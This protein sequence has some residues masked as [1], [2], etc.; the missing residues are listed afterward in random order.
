MTV[1]VLEMLETAG[2]MVPILTTNLKAF[3]KPLTQFLKK[4]SDYACAVR[5]VTR[6][7]CC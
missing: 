2:E 4:V 6:F 3:I 1:E 5:L 7:T